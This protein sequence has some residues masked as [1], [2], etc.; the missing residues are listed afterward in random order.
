MHMEIPTTAHP[1]CRHDRGEGPRNHPQAPRPSVL[2][3][4]DA[5]REWLRAP[6]GSLVAETWT[7]LLDTCAAE[8]LTRAYFPSTTGHTP[9][10]APPDVT[11][12]GAPA[13]W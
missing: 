11:E 8:R 5:S 1:P 12:N 9:A 6:Y 2:T 10:D 3:D 7:P 13:D 4:F